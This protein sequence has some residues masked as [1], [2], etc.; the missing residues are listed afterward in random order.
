MRI[1]PLGDSVLLVRVVDEFEPEKSLDA[2]LRAIRQLEVAA[3][4]GLIE[5]VPA[6]TTIG[7]FFDPAR[8]GAFAKLKAEIE[9]ALQR[10][11]EPARP[12]AGTGPGAGHCVRT[13]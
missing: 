13:P 4:P 2:V 12:R 1:E 3:L 7:V 5:L 6:Y 10:D 8:A 11:L 9:K